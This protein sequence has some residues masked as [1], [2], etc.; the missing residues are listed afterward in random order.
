MVESRTGVV[1][2]I[3][4]AFSFMTTNSLQ[5]AEDLTAAFEEWNELLYKYAFV[6]LRSKEL[7]ED[8]IQEVFTKA[9]HKRELFDPEK[10]SLKNWL[11]VIA[12]NTIRDH[13]RTRKEYVELETDIESSEDIERQISQKD[14]VNFVFR[15][16]RK[17]SERDQELL[18]L[19]YVQGFSAKEVAKIVGMKYSAT[20]VAFHRAIKKLQELCN[21][22]EM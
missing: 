5:T 6:R 18:T 19:R 11:F 15:Y 17:L 20:K 7:S 12:T 1:Y 10:S 8:V 22:G 4:T 13:Y 16:I 9:W 3:S 2:N 14:L 21:T